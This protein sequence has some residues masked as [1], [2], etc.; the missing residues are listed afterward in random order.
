MAISVLLFDFFGTLVNYQPDR[1]KIEYPSSFQFLLQQCFTGSYETFNKIW[2][3]CFSARSLAHKENLTEFTMKEITRDM[4]LHL[5]LEVHDSQLETFIEI[6]LSEWNKG[7]KDIEGVPDLLQH[8]SSRFRLGI[9]SNTHHSP[10]VEGHL[11]RLGIRPYF[12]TVV[13]SDRVGYRKP[14][15]AVFEEALTTLRV[16]PEEAIYIGDS[17]HEDYVGARQSEIRCLLIDPDRRSD[18]DEGDRID[19]VL[20]IRQKIF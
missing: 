19:D 2:D 3:A 5:G 16:A 12:E 9:I 7:V 8:L 18:C 11:E 4:F 10:L 14:H 15:R 13:T 20:E 6:Y 17:F 1:L